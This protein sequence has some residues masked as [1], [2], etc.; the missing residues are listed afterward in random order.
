MSLE[1]L[2]SKREYFATNFEYMIQVFINDNISEH[3][4][5]RIDGET[6]DILK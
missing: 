2:L 3:Y 1:E 5:D 4:H 6:I